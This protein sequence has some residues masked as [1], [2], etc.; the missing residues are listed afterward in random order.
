MTDFER[1]TSR[2]ARAVTNNRGGNVKFH[3]NTY[4]VS[5]AAIDTRTATNSKLVIPFERTGGHV[6]NVAPGLDLHYN[7]LEAFHRLHNRSLYQKGA[8]RFDQMSAPNHAKAHL[9]QRFPN[10]GVNS[11]TSTFPDA[12]HSGGGARFCGEPFTTPQVAAAQISTKYARA[13]GTTHNPQWGTMLTREAREGGPGGARAKALFSSHRLCGLS[14]SY[15]AVDLDPTASC[16]RF[17][18][19]GRYLAARERR[20]REVR[21]LAR[22]RRE[23][24]ERRAA[25]DSEAARRQALAEG[26]AGAGGV[27]RGENG[28]RADGLSSPF[29]AGSGGVRRHSERS[30]YF[31]RG[32]VSQ[33]AAEA[34]E[35]SA[36]MTM[37]RPASA[38]EMRTDE[39]VTERV[40]SSVDNSYAAAAS[41][42]AGDATSL[43][44]AAAG[45]DLHPRR[46]SVFISASVHSAAAAAASSSFAGTAAAA[47]PTAPTYLDIIA[48]DPLRK[49]GAARHNG[50]GASAAAAAAN[51]AAPQHDSLNNYNPFNRP[52]SAPSSSRVP[53]ATATRG[54]AAANG[55]GPQA[56]RPPASRPQSAAP[57]G[58]PATAAAA[59]GGAVPNRLGRSDYLGGG[60]LRPSSVATPATRGGGTTLSFAREGDP[61]AAFNSST[62]ALARN[63][64]FSRAARFAPSGQR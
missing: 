60:L 4:N 63:L 31:V 19:D 46:P 8:V 42:A 58:R 41:T 5:Y 23:A 3:D 15:A 17:D 28:G 18:P 13:I 12:G 20:S 47:A 14:V 24:E 53:P 56:P 34:I 59:A 26:V 43:S 16:P 45:G 30:T 1:T 54:T 57:A 50:G 61:V 49:A 25:A 6:T 22:I 21:A 27:S 52:Y 51:V 7:D 38:A 29:A 39:D 10:A 40:N 9:D 11:A 2:A 37:A 35:A 62:R 32:G 44:T 36:L 64:T 55:S 33:T 48:P